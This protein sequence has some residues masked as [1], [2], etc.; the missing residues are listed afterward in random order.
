[1]RCN[2]TTTFLVRAPTA[3]GRIAH[4]VVEHT[5]GS[6]ASERSFFSGFFKA[7]AP[8]RRRGAPRWDPRSGRFAPCAHP[9]APRA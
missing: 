2:P 7:A 5:G 8:P 1:M 6:N 9:T 3:T 4:R